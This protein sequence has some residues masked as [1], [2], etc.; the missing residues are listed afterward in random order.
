MQ[1]SCE[2]IKLLL[3]LIYEIIR[4]LVTQGSIFIYNFHE[5]F[6]INCF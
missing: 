1:L 6:E 5:K 4:F 2:Y 3:I